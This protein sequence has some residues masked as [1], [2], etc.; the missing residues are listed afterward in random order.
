MVLRNPLIFYRT[1]NRSSDIFLLFFVS[2]RTY[3]KTPMTVAHIALIHRCFGNTH[4]NPEHPSGKKTKQIIQENMDNAW[5]VTCPGT[6]RYTSYMRK[7]SKFIRRVR[8]GLP[9]RSPLPLPCSLPVL[10][11]LLL[12]LL[13]VLLLPVLLQLQLVLLLP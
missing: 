9:W 8:Q 3:H 5:A 11:P 1:A 4:K 7:E 12:L 10:L 2:S 13:P 6:F